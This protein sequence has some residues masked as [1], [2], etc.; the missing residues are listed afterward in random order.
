[1]YCLTQAIG[2][3]STHCNPLEFCSVVSNLSAP[4]I[5]AVREI[6]F[7]HLQDMKMDMLKGSI[8]I[9][10]VHEVDLRN[11]SVRICGV[12][13][14]LSPRQF[15]QYMGISNGVFDVVLGDQPTEMASDFMKK[16]IRDKEGPLSGTVQRS[17]LIEVVRN[18][19]VA[20]HVFKIC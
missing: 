7:G 8:W 12:T 20:D 19:D 11:S 3:M 5:K 18:R 9:R 15:T 14:P 2:I 16:V 4:K 1:M 13:Y 17:D 10:M 6:G